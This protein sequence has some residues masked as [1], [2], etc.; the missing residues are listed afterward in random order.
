M[1][2]ILSEDCGA[3]TPHG[4]Y[5]RRPCKAG[6]QQRGEACPL[7]LWVRSILIY[8]CLCLMPRYH[9]ISGPVRNVGF[10]VSK[11]YHGRAGVGMTGYVFK[12]RNYNMGFQI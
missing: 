2:D 7:C 9:I 6:S 11:S 5:K 4:I 12:Y 1:S 3:R 8:S 10:T